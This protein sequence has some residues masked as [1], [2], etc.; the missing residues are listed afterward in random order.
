MIPVFIGCISV[1][2]N[3]Y[4]LNIA[5][6]FLDDALNTSDYITFNDSVSD[7]LL[8]VRDVEGI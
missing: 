5:D 3:I 1:R 8:I 6:V 2:L 7:E 4:N